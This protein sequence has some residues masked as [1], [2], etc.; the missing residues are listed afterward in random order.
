[1]SMINHLEL[2]MMEEGGEGRRRDLHCSEK[3][4]EVYSQDNT[5]DD[6]DHSK[7]KQKLEREKKSS[8]TLIAKPHPSVS[9][10]GYSPASDHEDGPHG[11]VMISRRVGGRWP[12]R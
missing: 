2:I 7:S 9:G 8:D 11:V 5:S 1:M 3:E 6:G 10:D 4:D 12:S